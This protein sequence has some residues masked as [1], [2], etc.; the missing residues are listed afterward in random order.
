MRC[1]PLT[2]P[3]PSAASKTD[4]GA[5]GS[6]GSML[7]DR[8][9]PLVSIVT[10]SYNQAQFLEE[11]ILSVLKQDY[12]NIEYIIIDGES[13]D[14]SVEIIRKYEN[15]IAYWLSEKDRGQ[16]NA[17]NKGLKRSCGEIVAYLN[18][19]DMYL[20]GT[21][22]RAVEYLIENSD[23]DVI[24]GD[25]RVVDE[26]NG[27]VSI[28][29]SREFDLYDELCRNFIYQPTVFM[30]RRVLNWVGYF[31]ED[32]NYA[33][34]IDYWYRA[35]LHA[36]FAYIP[37]ELAVFRITRD[38]KTGKNK[39]LFVRERETVLHRFLSKCADDAITQ[40]RKGVLAWHHY[41]GGQQL[42]A[43]ADFSSAR[44][45]FRKSIRL[46]PLSL[47]AC[48]SFLGIIDSYA[49][50]RFFQKTAARMRAVL[51]PSRIRR[52]I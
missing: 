49:N 42:Y 19:D 24:Y 25:C 38:S 20:D 14:G 36:T 22:S 35:A 37:T 34:D 15:R 51:R 7:D 50:T 16:S 47:K 26:R 52:F 11:T 27:T 33:M 45:E 21:I 4:R 29:R 12:P 41:H 40:W 43:K 32:L 39:A 5:G 9:W 10:P 13:R 17:I 23:V 8:Q 28:W 18:S 31:D 30:R 48:L 2:E 1:S 3:Q 44:R 6:P 46:E